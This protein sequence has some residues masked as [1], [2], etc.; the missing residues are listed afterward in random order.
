MIQLNE[1][2]RGFSFFKCD[3]WV[4]RFRGFRG[5][6]YFLSRFIFRVIRLI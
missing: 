5:K 3:A 1:P 4:R 2:C 6:S